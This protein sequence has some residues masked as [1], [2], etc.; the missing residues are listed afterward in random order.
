M[1]GGLPKFQEIL[2]LHLVSGY[3]IIHLIMKEERL[4]L[5]NPVT[6]PLPHCVGLFFQQQN[7]G[8]AAFY[9]WKTV[10]SATDANDYQGMH[11][12]QGLSRMLK[13]RLNNE[14]EVWTWREIS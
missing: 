1:V 6:C 12:T 5:L 10:A 8:L 4:N 11:H 2:C 3:V 7:A 13:Q 14:A 9:C